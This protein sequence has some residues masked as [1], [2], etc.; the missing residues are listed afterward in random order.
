MGDRVSEEGVVAFVLPDALL[1]PFER[2]VWRLEDE[3]YL[4]AIGRCA[5]KESVGDVGECRLGDKVRDSVSEGS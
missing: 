5:S 3:E 2:P 4:A 1:V